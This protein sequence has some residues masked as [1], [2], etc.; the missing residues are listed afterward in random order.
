MSGTRN[1]LD[2]GRRIW[3][4]GRPTEVDWTALLGVG[5][6]AGRGASPA[7][8]AP[9]RPLDPEMWEGSGMP[10]FP[11]PVLFDFPVLREWIALE[12]QEATSYMRSGFG[13]LRAPEDAAEALEML[14][15]SS[16]LARETSHGYGYTR[17]HLQDDE[18]L[19]AVALCKDCGRALLQA[20]WDED[21][22]C[23]WDFYDQE[24]AF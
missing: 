6:N 5:R 16:C 18:V 15:V 2:R 19:W 14:S 11:R 3:L 8:G 20:H 9:R 13:F 1:Y 4:E 12:E 21:E 24:A 23:Q 22:G 10:Y 17:A 7:P